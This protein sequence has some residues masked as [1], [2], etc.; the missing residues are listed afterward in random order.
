M[1]LVSLGEIYQTT[2]RAG[3]LD[4]NGDEVPNTIDSRQR[5]HKDLDSSIAHL[6]EHVGKK[7]LKGYEF[8]EGDPHDP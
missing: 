4:S 6:E 8:F 3:K 1:T 5:E 7:L 2:A